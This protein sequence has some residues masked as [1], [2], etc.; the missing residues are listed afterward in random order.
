[1]DTFTAP[2]SFG[3]L[4]A[5]V[6]L[7]VMVAAVAMTFAV[8]TGLAGRLALIYEDAAYRIRSE[9]TSPVPERSH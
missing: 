6:T 3:S 4:L 5:L 7:P 9:S 8:F 2:S 1:M